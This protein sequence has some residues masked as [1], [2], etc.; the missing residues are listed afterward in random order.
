MF[1]LRAAGLAL[2]N[3]NASILDAVGTMY[4]VPECLVSLTRNILEAIP[5]PILAGITKS[6]NSGRDSAMESIANFKR[7]ILMENG[8]IEIDTESGTF[9]FISSSSRNKLDENSENESSNLNDFIEAIGF[10]AAAGGELYA[11]YNNVTQML[12]GVTDCLNSYK[13]FLELNKGNSS[14]FYDALAIADLYSQELARAKDAQDFI[15]DADRVISDINSIVL[16][17]IRDPSKEPKFNAD[18]VPSGSELPTEEV[19][20]PAPIFRLVF[21]PPKSKKGQFL[22]SVDGLYYDSQ[23]G[24][25]PSVSGIIPPEELYSFNYPANLGGKGTVMTTKDITQYV[26]TIFDPDQVDDSLEIQNHYNA[27]HFL[28]VLYGQ[29]HRHLY[30]LSGQIQSV[31]QQYSVDSAMYENSFQQLMAADAMHLSKINKRKKQIEIAIKAPLLFG[32]TREF[33]YGEVPVNDFSFLS[34]L[35]LKVA[36]AKQRKLVFAQGEVSGVVL[37]LQ[38]KFVKASESEATPYFENLIVPPVGVGSLLFST[39]GDSPQQ[40]LSLTDSIITDN[41]IAVYNFLESDITTYPGSN[42]YTVLNCNAKSNKEKAAQLVAPNASSVFTSGLSIP[43]FKGMVS[44][45]SATGSLSGLGSYVQLPNHADFQNLMYNPKGCTIEFWIHVPDL[46]VS[47]TSLNTERGWSL[48]SFH[49]LILACE[50][51]GGA[52]RNESEDN[53]S[54]NYGSDFVRGLVCGFTRDSQIV[55]NSAASN[56]SGLDP[57]Y[58]SSVHFYLAPTRSFNASEVGFLRDTVTVECHSDEYKTL[59]FSVP[60]DLTVNNTSI[61]DVSSTFCHV[62]LTID[63]KE[64]ALKLYFDRNLMATSALNEVFGSTAFMAP[65]IP[66]F[67]QNGSFSYSQGST[68]LTEFT[69]GPSVSS[70]T[71]W[72]VGGGFTDGKSTGFMAG[73]NGLSSGLG[74]FIGSLKF[75]SKPLTTIEVQSNY[76]NQAPYFKNIDIVLSDE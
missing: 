69:Y 70:F 14:N 67:A 28:Q 18:Y 24:G 63:P 76:D 13:T 54:V 32:A 46:G 52:N 68:G 16:D 7:K 31:A 38:P 19:A 40:V 41:L 15:N 10:A 73:N 3:S 62:A 21:G 74:G 23:S 43:F 71:P 51:S 75:Y 17:R 22:L 72:I 39:S 61:A 26:D 29:R 50:N 55:T 53:L 34:K 25:L 57:S 11:N 1:D 65:K 60:G 5:T 30:I 12:A 37:P 44:R 36:T 9:R 64:N 35:N 8:F 33:N 45:S 66:S 42:E 27:D 2:G 6:L 4:G 49:K 59:K 48:S 47:S 56:S 58:L 20:A